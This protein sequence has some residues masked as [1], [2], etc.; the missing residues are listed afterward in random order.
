[1]K[2]DRKKQARKTIS[3]VLAFAL[4]CTTFSGLSTIG[5]AVPVN[6]EFQGEEWYDQLRTYEVNREPGH[7]LFIPYESAEKALENEASALDEDEPSAYYQKLSGKEWDFALVTTPAEAK[8]KDEAW[9][10]ETLSAE[11]QA[12]F[13]KEYVPQSWQTYR[14]ERG[15]FK[16]DSP[17]Y[18][19]QSYPWQNFESRNDSA[20]GYAATVYNPVG[21]YR[22]TFETPESFEGRQTFITFEGVESAYYVY[23]NGQEVGYS[24]DS[25]TAHDFNITP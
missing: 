6:P 13:N 2:R 7:S 25:Y 16:Y 11:D 24:E 10:A 22:T 4:A 23:V 21:Y 15:D 14:D 19:N 20:N 5:S 9:L 18:T 1:M 12:A 17:I 8:K 3:L